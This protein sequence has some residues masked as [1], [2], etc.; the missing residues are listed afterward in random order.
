MKRQ[1]DRPRR[2]QLQGQGSRPALPR[3]DSAGVTEAA[4]P[5]RDSRQG[6]PAAR[7]RRLGDGRVETPQAFFA[8]AE[9]ENPEPPVWVG[10]LYL[11]LHRATLTSQAK[12]KQGNR[13]SEHLLREAELWAATA[14]VRTGFPY[15]AD[16][17]DRVWRDRPAAPVPRHPARLVHRLGCTARARATYDRVTDELNGI[18]DAAQRALAGEGDT[19]LVFNSAPHARSG[20]RAG[21]ATTPAEEGPHR[22]RPAPPT[23]GTSW[24]TACCAWRSTTGAGRVGV[25]H[26]RGP[27]DDRAGRGRQPAPAPLRLPEHVGRLGRRR[28]LPQHGPRPHRRRRGRPRRRRRLGAG[29]S[30]PSVPPA[31]PR[32]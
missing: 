5:P 31:S 1:R 6:G 17:L 14:A 9:A 18:I 12:T 23:A 16:D 30:A 2:P 4:A 25:R 27:R 29:S 13:R 15:P 10:E 32:C 24:R 26:R 21:A 22:P 8:K 28:V 19:R 7:P 20:V 3:P 11:E